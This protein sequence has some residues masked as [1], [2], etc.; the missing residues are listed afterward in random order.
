MTTGS[1]GYPSGWREH[2]HRLQETGQKPPRGLAVWAMRFRVAKTLVG[3]RLDGMSGKAEEGYFV[4]LKVTL[5]DTALEA[6]ESALD[7]RPGSIQIH[8]PDLSFE[9]WEHRLGELGDIYR[10]LK[11]KKLKSELEVFFESDKDS[12]QKFDL[13]AIL[14]ALRHLNSHGEFTPTSTSLYTSQHYRDLVLGLADVALKTCEHVFLH[15][16]KASQ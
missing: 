4:G 13:R 14:R 2:V 5:A 9:L 6:L 1:L 7:L 3:I 11:N 12:C 10:L 8:D 16:V 15:S